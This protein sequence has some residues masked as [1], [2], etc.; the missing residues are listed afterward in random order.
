MVVAVIAAVIMTMMLA[1]KAASGKEVKS[2][3]D[4][5][6]MLRLW[7]KF[8][9]AMKLGR[10]PLPLDRRRGS[11]TRTFR[12]IVQTGTYPGMLSSHS[13]LAG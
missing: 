2:Q 8:V 12:Y 9:V 1:G 13:Q 3:W 6:V 11:F 4:Y 5:V 7:E 10:T